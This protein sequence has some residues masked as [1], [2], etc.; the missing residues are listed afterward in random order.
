MDRRGFIGAALAALAVAGCSSSEE[1]ESDVSPSADS[2]TSAELTL[3]YWDKNQTKTI[4]QNLKSFAKKYPN[5][6]IKTNLAGFKD[7]WNKL[8]TQ[9]QGNELPDVFWMNG[10]NI[11]LY[12]ANG[13]LA[14]IDKITGAGVKWSNY[15]KALDDL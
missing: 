15:P 10:P 13:M 1:N 2:K 12:A 5:I 3:A 14:P 7:Y 8:R 11:Q 4:E 6:K 9:A